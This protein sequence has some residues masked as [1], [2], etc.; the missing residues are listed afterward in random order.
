MSSSNTLNQYQNISNYIITNTNNSLSVSQ[1]CTQ[2]PYNI[3]N[4]NNNNNYYNCSSRNKSEFNEFNFVNLN[5][6]TNTNNNTQSTLRNLEI[7]NPIINIRK[8]CNNTRTYYMIVY[9]PQI[10]TIIVSMVSLYG[11]FM[12]THNGHNGTCTSEHLISKSHYNLQSNYRNTKFRHVSVT[13]KS[14]RYPSQSTAYKHTNDTI[15]WR[16]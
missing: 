16:T 1:S 9:I 14:S 6:V 3:Q 13:Q 11:A 2:I 4:D 5:D 8:T 12:E 10:I 15:A 7:I